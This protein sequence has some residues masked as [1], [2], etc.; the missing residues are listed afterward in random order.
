MPDV[1]RFFQ[2]YIFK[3][4]NVTME[5]LR[6]A[7]A[8]GYTALILTVDQPLLRLPRSYNRSQFKLPV[9]LK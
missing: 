2:L 3:E 1:V 9:H 5:L 7:E 6:R 4:R 8:S